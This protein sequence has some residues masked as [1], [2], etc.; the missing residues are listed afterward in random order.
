MLP[1]LGSAADLKVQPENTNKDIEKNIASVAK[2]VQPLDNF[3]YGKVSQLASSA[4]ENW[5]KQYGNARITLN[6]QHDNSN[7]LAGSSADLLFGLHNQEDRLDYV[8]FDTHYQ[9]SND[10]IFNAGIGQRY[11][12]N[13]KSMLGYNVFY[14]RNM[15]TDV[16]RAGVGIEL[17]RDYFKFS[18]NGY[19][20]LSDW[21][22]SDELQDYDE[23][24]AN[25][26]DLQVEG[27][28]PSYAQLG[29]HVKFE[30]YFGDDVALFGTDHLQTDPSAVTLGVSYTPIP[31]ITF[32]LDYKKGNDSLDD[33]AI[34]A[35]F[36]YAFGVPWSQQIS[37]DYVQ[38]RRSLMGSRFDF[39]ER[40]NDIVMQYRK[41]D[42]IKLSLPAQLSGQ[43]TQQVSLAASVNAKNGLDH[44]QWDS[45]ST[46]LRAGGSVSAG[47]DATHFTVTLPAVA[48][49]YVLQGK[50]YD[51]H[52][53]ASNMAQ[54]R[55]TVSSQSAGSSR[56]TFAT[57]DTAWTDKT[58]KIS[59]SVTDE[60]GVAAPGTSITFSAKDC[61]GTS[62]TF[63]KTTVTAENQSGQAIASTTLSNTHEGRVTVQACITGTNS[64]SDE[65]IT[66]YAPPS[67]SGQL[68]LGGQSGMVTSLPATWISKTQF[69]LGTTAK[70]G[71]GNYTWH[72]S[73]ES[74]ATVDANGV[75]TLQN[76]LA[77][78]VISV[79]SVGRESD[80]SHSLSIRK[81]NGMLHITSDL[82][83]YTD[84]V[85][86]CSTAGQ[87]MPTVD[88]FQQI[89]APWGDMN[90]YPTYS[91][92]T[93][94]VWAK[95]DQAEDVGTVYRMADGSSHDNIAKTDLQYPGCI[96]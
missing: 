51:T 26:Y 50:A 86:S 87:A 42:V 70:G 73:N 49:Q 48:G 68:E 43:A 33:T 65:P 90:A 94:Y 54:T 61:S 81:G 96:E 72:S 38:T 14:D 80:S 53:N 28:L 67:L 24:A 83:N 58:E 19:F 52:N 57:P 88:D 31:L 18:S 29:G 89:T 91:A 75:V 7:A 2:S 40:N 76:Q 63:S 37:P 71:D 11:F 39:V 56:V 92:M 84:T 78:F 21:Q 74:A 8:Q 55:F 30:Q 35:A 95:S 82:K 15:N 64:C 41:Q 22:D 3:A 59:V 16:T 45:S 46:L 62:C 13:N 85:A 10:M 77:S 36:N 79:T 20:A 12:L 1:T 47:S 32:G 9:D 60:Q 44:I 34:S 69:K 4:V 25:G 5:L 6:S 27:F 17:W 23:K 66:F 93:K